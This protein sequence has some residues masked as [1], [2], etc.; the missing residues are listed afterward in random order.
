MKTADLQLSQLAVSH[1]ATGSTLT[2]GSRAAPRRCSIRPCPFGV[3][4]PTCWPYQPV[5]K[6]AGEQQQLNLKRFC[7]DSTPSAITGAGLHLT[8]S[9]P[10]LLP[11]GSISAHFSAVIPTCCSE[12]GE[13][14][15]PCSLFELQ[16]GKAPKYR[17]AQL[18]VRTYNTDTEVP[19]A[20]GTLLRG[21][22][23][24]SLPLPEP[25]PTP[26]TTHPR[27]GGNAENPPTT[28]TSFRYPH[29]YNFQTTSCKTQTPLIRSQSSKN[30]EGPREDVMVSG[31]S[32]LTSLHAQHRSQHGEQK[33]LHGAAMGPRRCAK[34]R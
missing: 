18:E 8:P 22:G 28:T 23:K 10:I 4:P 11:L 25:P 1:P 29:A 32:P 27:S 19:A 15:H 17:R 14:S 2:L 33:R 5:V 34:R 24:I 9:P 21:L 6:N 26:C 30:L 7:P 31:G 12:R 13:R 20:R 3:P 16:L